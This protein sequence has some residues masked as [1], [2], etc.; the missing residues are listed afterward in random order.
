MPLSLAR[1]LVEFLTLPGQLVVDL[2]GGT[3]K[4]AMAAELLERYWITFELFAEY[5]RGGAQRF[6]Q[7]PGFRLGD[8]FSLGFQNQP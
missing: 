3:A 8:E 6:Q 5:L 7:F 2:F 4:S 1:F